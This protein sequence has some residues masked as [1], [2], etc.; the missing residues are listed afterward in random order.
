MPSCTL[1]I[2]IYAIYS[3]F[4]G[5]I[6]SAIEMLPQSMMYSLLTVSSLLY[7]SQVYLFLYLKSHGLLYLCV[8]VGDQTMANDI[9]LLLS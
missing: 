5:C 2:T 9:D 7:V 4:I 1:P 3:S 8:C 6:T